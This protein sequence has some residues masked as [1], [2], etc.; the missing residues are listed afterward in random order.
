MPYTPIRFCRLL[1]DKR[2]GVR[3]PDGVTF[4]DLSAR[5][6]IPLQTLSS[7]ANG[8]RAP[9][10]EDVDLIVTGLRIAP[11]DRA[12]W[13]AAAAEFR[14][15]KHSRI[16]P[17]MLLMDRHQ[18]RIMAQHDYAVD[19]IRRAAAAIQTARALVGQLVSQ[20]TP[21]G[22]HRLP[23]GA[24]EAIQRWDKDAR[25]TVELCGGCHHLRPPPL[26]R[27]RA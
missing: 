11:E 2:V 14:A 12:E 20:A 22:P 4:G 16:A 8:H 5:T 6:E 13:H 17:D 23:A 9:P 26:R 19:V 25:H 1:R 18:R 24:R 7:Y 10:R 27:P 3:G 15:M 21:E